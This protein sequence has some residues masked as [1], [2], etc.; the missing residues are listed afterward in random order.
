MVTV[1]IPHNKLNHVM[2][3]NIMEYFIM[4]FYENLLFYVSFIYPTYLQCNILFDIKTVWHIG[5]IYD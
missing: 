1:N 3:H 4:K 2:V 5:Y